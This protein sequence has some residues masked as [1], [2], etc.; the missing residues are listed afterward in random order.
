MNRTALSVHRTLLALPLAALLAAPVAR[1][2]P[3]DGLTARVRTELLRLPYYGPFDLLS[4]EEANGRVTLGGKVY[5]PALKKQAEEAVRE[6]P[7]VKEVADRIEVL[8]ASLG[9]DRIRRIAFSR[10]YSDPFLS[11]YGSPE[12]TWGHRLWGPG[13]RTRPAF[14]E[15]LWATAPYFGLE[16]VGHYAIHVLVENGRVTLWGSVASQAERARAEAIVRE[17][18][19]VLGVEDRIEVDGRTGP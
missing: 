10:L 15:G 5:L 2:T 7:G 8:P 3:D 14:R 1:A 9:D 18:P 17:I 16:P 19:A 11:R 4:F 12:G 6:L 13:L